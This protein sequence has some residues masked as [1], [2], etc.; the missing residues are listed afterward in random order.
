M[1]NLSKLWGSLHSPR[2]HRKVR[3]RR[4]SV[5]R[6]G[7][8]SMPRWK[9][10]SSS[11]RTPRERAAGCLSRWR[12][13]ARISHLAAGGWYEHEGYQRHQARTCPDCHG[14]R[15]QNDKGHPSLSCR[16]PLNLGDAAT[17]SAAKRRLRKWWCGGVG[18]A[19][20]KNS[21]RT[22]THTYARKFRKYI[23]QPHH[24]TT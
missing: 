21:L 6:I 22:Y 4:R 5:R 24:Y 9:T 7:R 19:V 17:S 15:V 12:I 1:F 14:L 20:F 16:T 11:C 10:S 18:G 13:S 8:R 2:V 23:H 3:R